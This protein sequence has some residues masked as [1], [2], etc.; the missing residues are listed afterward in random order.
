MPA[1]Y[2]YQIKNILGLKILFDENLPEDLK[3]NFEELD[4]YSVNDL[5]WNSKKNGELLM[6][7]VENNFD[8]FVTLDK[9]LKYQQN[10]DKFAVNILCIRVADSKP[11]TFLP[12]ISKMKEYFLTEQK[13]SISK[14]ILNFY[15][16]SKL[17]WFSISSE[18]YASITNYFQTQIFRRCWCSQSLRS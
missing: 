5:K 9:N 6:L 18:I 1:K 15:L 17:S 14:S 12:L 7:M 3:V 13:L 10:L 8:V 2:L 4:V 16:S 11:E